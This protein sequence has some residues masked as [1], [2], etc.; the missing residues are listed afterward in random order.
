M[1]IKTTVEISNINAIIFL[2]IFGSVEGTR[3]LI[4]LT[5][6]QVSYSS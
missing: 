4:S 1:L 2:S 6:N 3:T 5:E